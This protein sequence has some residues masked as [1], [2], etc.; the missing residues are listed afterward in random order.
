MA[1]TVVLSPL[2]YAELELGTTF[3]KEYCISKKQIL[4][5]ADIIDDHN[6]IHVRKGIVHGVLIEC[7]VS[8]LVSRHF[9]GLPVVK[10]KM[11]DFGGAVYAEQK[12]R[13]VL[14]VSGRRPS[15]KNIRRGVVYTR[16]ECFVDGHDKPVVKGKIIIEVS[17]REPESS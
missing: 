6:P 16:A 14:T 13:I 10:R 8:G 12:I 2:R 7:L 11:T 17:R 3:E 4:Q 9:A 5:F 1:A 15:L